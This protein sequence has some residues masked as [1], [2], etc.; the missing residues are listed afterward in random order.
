[1]SFFK[2]QQ[3]K[4]E[5]TV[6]RDTSSKQEDSMEY[7]GY[8]AK[9]LLKK[10]DAYLEQEVD[11]TECVDAVQSRSENSLDEL[12]SIDGTIAN[13]SNSY[14]EFTQSAERIH[15]A[16]D[17][18]EATINEANDS[19]NNL[20]LHINDSRQQLQGMNQ[21]FEQLE[22]DFEKIA[23]LAD[24]ITGISSRTNLLALNASIEAARAG[25]AGRGFAVVAEQIRELS[26]STASLVKGI[27]DAIKELYDSLENL[28]GEIGET[29]SLIQNNIEYANNVKD[30]FGQVKECNYRVKEV[31]DYFLNE[32]SSTQTQV[33]GAVYGVES[34][35]QAIQNIQNEIQN[36]NHHSELKSVSLCEVVDILHQLNNIAN[37]A[38]NS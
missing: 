32:I 22:T 12:N 31:S 19:M 30:N 35:R 27:E 36:L 2:K 21:T 6:Y 24:G 38:K 33:Q 1:M 8:C 11:V 3:P 5:E 34:T 15:E 9:D 16:M 7:V 13:I 17:Q 4:E 18:S 28:Q 25:E 26:A 23:E 10:M 37:E 14:S 29:S 20:T